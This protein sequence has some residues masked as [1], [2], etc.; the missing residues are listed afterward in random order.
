MKRI[1]FLGLCLALQ[2]TV[3]AGEHEGF[4]WR[5]DFAQYKGSDYANVV[6]VER[7]ISLDQAFEIAEGNDEIDYFVYTKGGSMVL[8]VPPE[9]AYDQ[10]LDTFGLASYIDFVY[11]S[12]EYGRG[13]SRVFYYGDAIFFSKDGIWL[14]PAPG[15]ADAY[16]KTD[17]FAE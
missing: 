4:E 16:L 1:L 3:N 5:E 7:G 2:G 14:A 15:L 17:R 9:V 12:G 6:H 8:E 11:D 13:Y 10:A